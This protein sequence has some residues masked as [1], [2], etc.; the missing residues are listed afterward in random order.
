MN[1]KNRQYMS[2]ARIIELEN[3]ELK[4]DKI[5]EEKARKLENK[6]DLFLD[7]LAETEMECMIE[8]LELEPTKKDKKSAIKF[9]RGQL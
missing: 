5:K 3:A 7:D 9:L 8:A 6:N 4:A 2:R 1:Y